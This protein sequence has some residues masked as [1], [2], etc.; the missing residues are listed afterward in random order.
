MVACC[1][2]TG[3]SQQHSFCGPKSQHSVSAPEYIQ[4]PRQNVFLV[5][6][7]TGCGICCLL[8][9]PQHGAVCPCHSCGTQPSLMHGC[10]TL[11]LAAPLT[12]AGF[13]A[14]VKAIVTDTMLTASSQHWHIPAIQAGLV[15]VSAGPVFIC[16]RMLQPRCELQT[17]TTTTCCTVSTSMAD[18]HS[19]SQNDRPRGHVKSVLLVQQQ[20]I[21]STL[22]AV[23]RFQTIAHGMCHNL[24]ADIS[25][26]LATEPV[27]VTAAPVGQEKGSQTPSTDRPLPAQEHQR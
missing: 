14:G 8:R 3:N 2:R 13:P 24:C 7:V 18:S 6:S 16:L 27:T 4:C 10:R 21:I 15:W 25:L 23:R 26:P 11:R 9:L 5:D 17:D 19:H 1:M 12:C 22:V 20:L